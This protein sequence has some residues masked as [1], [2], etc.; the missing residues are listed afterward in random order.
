MPSRVSIAVAEI[1]RRPIDIVGDQHVS[2]ALRTR[3]QRGR[4]RRTVPTAAARRRRSPAL[5]GRAAPPSRASEVGRA[6]PAV[7]VARAVR[8]HVLGGGIEHRRG[9]IDGRIDETVMGER[10][11][12]AGH[13]ARVRLELRAGPARCVARRRIR[14]SWSSLVLAA[15]SSVLTASFGATVNPLTRARRS[16]SDGANR[17]EPRFEIRPPMRH[18]RLPGVTGDMRIGGAQPDRAG[19]PLR[20]IDHGECGHETRCHHACRRSG[21]RAA[22]IRLGTDPQHRQA[23]RLAGVRRQPGPAGLLQSR[24]PRQLDRSR[25]RPLPRASRRRSSTT[26]PRSSSRRSPP[27]TASP[28]CSRARSTCCRATRP[29][30]CS[31]DTSLGLNFAAVNYY[32]GQGFMVRKALEDQFGARAQRRVGVHADRNHHGA[33]PR[34]LFPRQQDE[35]RGA[36][37]GDRRRD[38]QGLRRRPLRRV[39]H[40]RVAALCREAQAHQRQRSHHPARDDLEG[41]ART[42]RAPRRRPVVRHRQVDRTS[43]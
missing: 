17:G 36:G 7:N 9:V 24:R 12:P 26:P 30:R 16:F 13:Q 20:T 29:G 11:A 41:A 22:G 23:A 14:V 34:R 5:R 28:R 1:A 25:R 6:A 32:D 31:R 27:R 37:A 35:V 15:R 19:E 21:S 2:P 38:H 39:H 33:Q 18:C 43:P 3:E 40:R 8:D 10:V 4:D 42:G